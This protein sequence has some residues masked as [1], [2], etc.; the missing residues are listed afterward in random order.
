[1]TTYTNLAPIKPE[2]EKVALTAIEFFKQFEPD[3]PLP[4][5]DSYRLFQLSPQEWARRYGV[6][7]SA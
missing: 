3:P 1:M 7:E 2:D 5:Y 4:P 6:M